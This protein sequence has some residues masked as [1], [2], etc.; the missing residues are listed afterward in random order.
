MAQSGSISQTRDQYRNVIVKITGVTQ[1]STSPIFHSF[2]YSIGSFTVQGTLGA[3]PSVQLQGSNDGGITWF[4]VG[5]PLTTAGS[6]SLIGTN[7]E[8]F[9]LYQF[10][11]TGGDGTTSFSCFVFLS[12]TFG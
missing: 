5:S 11:M 9:Q 8:V 12:A 7:N 4:A 1:T 6:G 2:G 10:A 3:T